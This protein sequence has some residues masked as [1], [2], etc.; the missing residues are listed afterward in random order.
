MF[1]YMFLVIVDAHSKWLEVY[2]M[3]STTTFKTIESLRDC[4]ARS[5]L[6]VTLVSDNGPQFTSHEFETF[7]N[8]NGIKH[9]TTAPF[10]PSSNGQAER[11]VKQN[12]MPIEENPYTGEDKKQFLKKPQIE[13]H[14]LVDTR[15]NGA[16]KR[17]LTHTGECSSE[18]DESSFKKL[19][20]PDLYKRYDR[21]LLST[22]LESMS[23]ITYCP[24][25]D[26]QCACIIDTCGRMGTCPACRFVF[27][28][29]CK[30][31]YHGVAPC[32]F[33]SEQRKRIFYEYTKGDFS[34][35]ASMEKCYGKR[36]LKALVEDTLSERWKTS[37]SQNCPHCRATIEKDEGCNKMTC[38]KCGSVFCWLC[39]EKKIL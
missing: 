3:K 34:V 17:H 39:T 25:K 15:E 13:G 27:C 16:L 19:V 4:F 18:L 35:K 36:V 7:M 32:N 24:R 14:L 30:M 8:S 21:L 37:N 26:C 2:P 10:K 9:K 20:R 12:F 31:T 6:P 23:D 22:T 28:P 5:G 11:Y 33:K 1:G 38:I 29:F